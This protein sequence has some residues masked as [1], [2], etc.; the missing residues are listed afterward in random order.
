[1]AAGECEVKSSLWGAAR[2]RPKVQRSRV[3]EEEE[4]GDEAVPDARL[5]I[6]C[7][8]SIVG[9]NRLEVDETKHRFRSE[10]GRISD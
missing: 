4:S 8:C 5:S 2:R 6:D 9:T 3:E 1:V 7:R 10:L